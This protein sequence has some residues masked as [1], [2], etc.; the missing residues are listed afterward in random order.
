MPKE[1]YGG[2]DTDQTSESE[3]KVRLDKFGLG[4]DKN[5]RD[6]FWEIIN[7][8]AEKKELSKETAEIARE[9]R[10]TLI[11]IAIGIIEKRQSAGYGL[12]HQTLARYLL[13]FFIDMGWGDAVAEMLAKFAEKKLTFGILLSAIK[14][15]NKKEQYR[16]KMKT[17]FKQL[18]RNPNVYPLALDYLSKMNDEN[19]AI[20]VK[21]ELK[22]FA[23]G[24]A[25]ENQIK[26][27]EALSAIDDEE[28]AG[29]IASLLS[30]WDV[31]IRRKAA[32]SLRKMNI[33][34]DIIKKIKEK[35]ESESDD[36]VRKTLRKVISKWKK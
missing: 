36:E 4:P 35:I 7:S 34:D 29:I 15:M 28:C 18:M 5:I 16:E 25:L 22:M 3:K 21:D 33:N 30:N 26:A 1:T 24:D 23:Q 13:E 32:E 14:Q 17:I 11:N 31:E 20:T 8:K 27:I 19:I 6:L 2:D 12:S 10:F 9:S